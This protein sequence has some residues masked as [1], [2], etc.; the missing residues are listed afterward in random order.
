M[1]PLGAVSLKSSV[2]MS[3]GASGG[4]EVE[5]RLQPLGGARHAQ[6][7]A[8]GLA[9]HAHSRLGFDVEE[10]LNPIRVGEVEAAAR[11][12]I[13][14]ALEP[15][16]AAL[17]LGAA[18]EQRPIERAAQVEVG[19]GD[20]ARLIVFDAQRRRRDDA[21]VVAQRQRLAAAMRARRAGQA[22]DSSPRRAPNTLPA[23]RSRA[24]SS[25]S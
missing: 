24:S 14:P 8:I 12:L 6:R 23:G 10:R 4:S 18:E 25:R 5:L 1:S 11:D 3:I 17:D 13:A 21:H 9:G 7:H 16:L 22:A 20:D 19:A 15:H 2:R